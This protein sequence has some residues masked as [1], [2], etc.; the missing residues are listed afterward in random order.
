MRGRHDGQPVK[1]DV[2]RT[3]APGYAWATHG[4]LVGV[5]VVAIFCLLLLWLVP[6]DESI[7]SQAGRIALALVVIFS[8]ALIAWLAHWLWCQRNTISILPFQ[9][10]TGD[11]EYD[12]V[13]AG[14]ADLLTAEIQR[15][16]GLHTDQEWLGLRLTDPA[17]RSGL[18]GGPGTAVSTGRRP[19]Q[20]HRTDRWTARGGAQ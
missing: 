20:P 7:W 14:F 4:G 15:L 19:A 2:G 12:T 11:E 9:T 18:G 17:L 8:L 1:V 16:T 3:A 13:A 5:L 10:F 6:G